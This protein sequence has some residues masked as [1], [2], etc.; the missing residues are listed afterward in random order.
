MIDQI[1]GVSTVVGFIR[2]KF[3]KKFREERLVDAGL[4]KIRASHDIINMTKL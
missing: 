2:G 3:G 1:P 4:K